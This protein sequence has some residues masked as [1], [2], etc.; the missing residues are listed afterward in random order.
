MGG[1]LLYRQWPDILVFID[2]QTDFYGETLTREYEQVIT[3]SEGWE[4]ILEK[5]QVDWM[6]IPEEAILAKALIEHTGWETLYEDET[7][8][9]IKRVSKK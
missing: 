6:L 2:G 8:I 7:A 5:Y 1:Y 9:I 4:Q 3:L